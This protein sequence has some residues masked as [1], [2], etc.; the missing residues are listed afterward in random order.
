MDAVTVHRSGTVGDFQRTHLGDDAYMIVVQQIT[1]IRLVAVRQIVA[2]VSRF[3][4]F[5]DDL[6]HKQIS[7]FDLCKVRHLFPGCV[8]T[9]VDAI[10][11]STSP[12][13]CADDETDAVT[14]AIRAAAADAIIRFCGADGFKLLKKSSQGDAHSDSLPFSGDPATQT[15]PDST[16][17]THGSATPLPQSLYSA[18]SEYGSASHFRICFSVFGFLA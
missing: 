9:A 16:K 3:S 7:G 10:P 6:T 8:V 5:V 11:A 15:M 4:G 12:A 14:G 18:A 13:D 2:A 17:K 1:A